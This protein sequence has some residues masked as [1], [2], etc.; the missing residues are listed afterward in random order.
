MSPETELARRVYQMESKPTH[1]VY[2]IVIACVLAAVIIGYNTLLAPKV[3]GIG[4]VYTN[5]DV[6]S[7]TSPSSPPVSSSSEESAAAE[8]SSFAPPQSAPE[9]ASPPE[10]S[11]KRTEP[12]STAPADP[13]SAAPSASSSSASPG[14]VNINTATADQLETLPGIGEVKAQ[15]I[16]QYRETYGPFQSVDELTLVKGIGEKTLQ[17]LLPYICV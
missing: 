5:Y 1:E 16:I 4:V 13:S 3:N 2:L 15:A 10:S 17:K 8:S 6:S 7:Q 11:P 12:A 14:I 9:D